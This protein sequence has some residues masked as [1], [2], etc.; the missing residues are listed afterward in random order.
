[1]THKSHDLVIMAPSVKSLQY[2]LDICNAELQRILLDFNAKKSV[3]MKF[4]KKYMSD[5]CN[6]NIRLGNDFLN[7]TKETKYLGFNLTY[8]L[9]NFNDIIRERNRFYNTFNCLLR[10]FNSLNPNIFMHIFK[11]Y[12][13]QFYGT[14]LWFNNFRCITALR[15]FGV[16]F[17]KSLKKIFKIP[18][19]ES[20]HMVCE[21]L[22]MVTFEH[23][24]DIIKMKFTFKLFTK[25]PIFILKNYNYFLTNSMLLK[26]VT[27]FMFYKYDVIDFL[28]NDIS[29][30]IARIFYVHNHVYS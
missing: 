5:N 18:Y 7:F 14:E 22:N 20:N 28:D 2:L 4:S 6:F 11:S 26:D 25:R 27:N 3:C 30:L 17:H 19:Y 1:M 10:R 15:Q 13:I 29:A 21:A 8:N 9:C 24:L 12:C 16:G 23:Q